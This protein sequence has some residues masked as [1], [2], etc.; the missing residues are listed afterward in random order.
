MT[1][2]QR[3]QAR[4]D[5]MT[6]KRRARMRAFLEEFSR[7][8]NATRSAR[9]CGIPGKTVFDWNRQSK[10]RDDPQFH[11]QFESEEPIPFHEAYE[12][13]RDLA[14]NDIEGALHDRA[15]NGVAKGVYWRGERV[16]EDRVFDTNAAALLLRRWR[17]E[18][19]DRGD[20][21]VNHTGKV[22]H[23][24]EIESARERLLDKLTLQL[25]RRHCALPE[26]APGLAIEVQPLPDPVPAHDKDE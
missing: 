18:Y 4:A 16:G 26:A 1:R 14:L 21:N 17:P 5:T 19:R 24:H 25:E 13:A 3:D 2:E 20:V 11:V 7:T 15:V 6:E 10:E 22:I 23:Q 9:T 12:I 8:G